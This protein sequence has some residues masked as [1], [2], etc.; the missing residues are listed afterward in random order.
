MIYVDDLQDYPSG[1]WCHMA[2]DGELDELHVMAAKI[3][4]KRS[5]FQNKPRHPCADGE[6]SA[7]AREGDSST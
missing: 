1:R 2:T 6:R 3:G 7:S 4:L 5:W